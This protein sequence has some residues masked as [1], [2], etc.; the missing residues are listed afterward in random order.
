MIALIGIETHAN[1][2]L[3][4]KAHWLVP[5]GRNKQF[6]GR[7]SQLEE[8]FAKL[9]LEDP[10]DDCQ[11]VAIAGLGGV[12]K[13]QIA[14]EAAFRV[15][16][17]SPDRSVFW[18]SATSA[19][20]FEKGLHDIG[21]AL[22]IPGIN[23]DKADVKSLV[24]TFLS[25]ESAGR[26]LLI[27]DNADDIEILYGRANESNESSGSP[28]LA[29]YLPFSRKGSILFTTRNL[30]A[31]VKQAG[32]NVIILKEMSEGDSQE[33]LQ[34]SLI[35]KSLIGGEIVI[36][37]LLD[38]LTRL[39]LAI[40]QAAAY[41]NENIMSIFDYL[42]LY[43]ANDEDLI[44]LLSIGF[45]DQGRY[46]EVKN[47]IASTWLISFRQISTRDPLAKKYLSFMSCV[48]QQDV[49]HSLL[50][51]A[52]KREGLEAIGTLKAYSFIT[53]RDSQDSYYIHRLVRI[54][55]RNWLKTKNEFSL[56]SGKALIQ[57]AKVFPFPGHENKATWTTYL[58]HAQS[59]LSFQEY[60]GD[61]EGSQ[62]DLLFNVGN[63]FQISGKYKE[64]ERMQ[65]RALEMMEKVLGQEHPDTLSSM[66]SL[67]VVL[68]RQGKYEEAERMHRR[69]LELRE[70]VLGQ[71]HKSTLRSMNNLAVALHSQGKY[72]EAERMHR[73]AL[74]LRE[75]VL[76]QEHPDTQRSMNDL[77][78]VLESQGKYEEAE[79]MHRRALELREKVLGQEHPDTLSSMDDLALVLESQGKYEEAEQ[80]HRRALE[81]M[82][83]S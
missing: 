23:E 57:V 29:D 53:Q 31:A 21:Q 82:S 37:K 47:P 17:E 73:R 4:P 28:A 7:H 60:S 22:Q 33:L 6:I 75:K 52:T 74:E 8:L 59:V 79:Q 62:R 61:F 45:E 77:A 68:R 26:W 70:R 44:H 19:A 56:W 55:M 3:A 66:N 64:A 5:F 54:A 50:P 24:K 83:T 38:N 14:L 30:R 1:F 2:F 11:R 78:V 81:A 51:L 76:G 39:P 25:Q 67:A 63:C 27:I 80:T 20:S 43:E 10:E 12:G 13:T 65:R 41:M 16:K 46:R 40:K 34:T 9:D 42:G 15:Q 18:I 35:D 58:P 69:A 36:A 32:A 72:E 71:E 49:P 48:A